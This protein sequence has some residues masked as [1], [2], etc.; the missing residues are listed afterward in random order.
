[1][2]KKIK[3]L[4]DSKKCTST[5]SLMAVLYKT[6]R[7][8]ESMEDYSQIWNQIRTDDEL[9]KSLRVIKKYVKLIDVNGSGNGIVLIHNA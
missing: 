9:K 4:Y 2:R 7:E 5:A 1:M 6:L 3:V 8:N